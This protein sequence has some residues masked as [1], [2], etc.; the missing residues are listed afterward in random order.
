[1]F[2]LDWPHFIT[3][4][5]VPVHLFTFTFMLFVVL[6]VNNVWPMCVSAL[7]NQLEALD[8]IHFGFA[9]QAASR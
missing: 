7:H 5:S 2:L 6:G 9:I 3:N 4:T 1:M 8:L